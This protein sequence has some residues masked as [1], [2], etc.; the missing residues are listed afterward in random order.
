M[1]KFMIASEENIEHLEHYGVKGMKWR[2]HK[3]LYGGAKNGA[4]YGAGLSTKPINVKPINVKP[5]T[6]KNASGSP[7][8]YTNRS[9]S[10]S[11]G[12]TVYT[13]DA[14]G[15]IVKVGEAVRDGA[16]RGGQ[17]SS[18]ESTAKKP[19]Y[20]YATRDEN[21]QLQYYSSK[22]EQHAA[23][24]KRKQAKKEKIKSKFKNLGER[25][26]NTAKGLKK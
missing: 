20:G 6:V 11:S 23:N 1:S 3:A 12:P 16:V 25:I 24:E 14:N 7:S 4:E 2:Q 26:K 8:N 19:S 21:G 10:K 15:K 17:H 5:I 13:K 18:K 22:G 9:T